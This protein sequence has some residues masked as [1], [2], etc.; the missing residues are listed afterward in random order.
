M[1]NIYKQLTTLLAGKN[2]EHYAPA[3]RE[4]F[5]RYER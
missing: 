2:E 3:T 1:N 5:F 4:Y